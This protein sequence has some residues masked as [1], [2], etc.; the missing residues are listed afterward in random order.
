M[1]NAAK[2]CRAL[3]IVSCALAQATIAHGQETDGTGGVEAPADTGGFFGVKPPS[4][5]VAPAP[6]PAVAYRPV[7]VRSLGQRFF[8]FPAETLD[9]LT[10][11]ENSRVA[12][13]QILMR[14]SYTVHPLA[15]GQGQF[16]PRMSQAHVFAPDCG[17]VPSDAETVFRNPVLLPSPATPMTS[18]ALACQP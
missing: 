15:S 18:V 16:V 10:Q 4:F 12:A 8:A 3:L 5:L 14:K 2:V 7:V 11:R 1:Q 6:P 13:W 17:R 9:F